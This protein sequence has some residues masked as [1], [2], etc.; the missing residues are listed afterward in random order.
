MFITPDQLITRFGADNIVRLSGEKPETEE[1]RK[2]LLKDLAVTV[3]EAC[4]ATNSMIAKQI[5]APEGA[6]VPQVLQQRAGDIAFYR[7]HVLLGA[8]L[9]GAVRT[10]YEAAIEHIARLR[11][12]GA[13]L[14]A[15]PAPEPK[16]APTARPKVKPKASEPEAK[17]ETGTKTEEA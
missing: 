14:E 9:R 15:P 17:P 1:E 10:P 6:V 5:A 12:A 16:P 11:D 7:L 13:R 2:K 3:A 8:P 4:A